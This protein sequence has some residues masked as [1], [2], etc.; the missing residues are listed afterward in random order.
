[1]NTFVT[2]MSRTVA[3]LSVCLFTIIVSSAIFKHI[4]LDKIVSIPVAVPNQIVSDSYIDLEELHCLAQN[5][6]Y[7]AGNQS[8]KGKAMVG[9]VVMARLGS[10]HFPDSICGVVKQ[11]NHDR[12]GRM[13]PYQC[14]FSWNCDKKS[15]KINY[16]NPIDEREW[17][18]SYAIARMIMENKLRINIDMTGVT[19]YHADY[20]KPD[21]SRNKNYKLVAKVGDH[22]FYKWRNATLPV[23][24]YASVN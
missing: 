1:M 17:E 13:I 4:Y 10:V 16:Y 9:F 21:W 11:G 23:A 20:V 15:H 5:I 12:H 3:F 14:S 19:H 22:L 24:Q 2:F 6:Y 7:E 8:A 18:Q